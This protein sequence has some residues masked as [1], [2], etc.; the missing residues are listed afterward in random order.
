MKKLNPTLFIILLFCSCEKIFEPGSLELQVSYC[1]N[2]YQG[3]KPDIGAQAHLYKKS[4]T[5][6]V[7]IDSISCIDARVGYLIDNKGKIMDID[8]D[9]E[10]EVGITGILTI[11][12]IK[13]G[14]YLL[15]LASEGRWTFSHKY[16]EINPGETL[17][18]V[19]N[20]GYLHE[21]EDGGEYW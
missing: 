12:N 18:L 19:K 20:F 21:F 17:K 3:Y 15:I 10:G 14:D 6:G 2:A 11:D 4:H 13:P 1:Y 8:D 7:F 16:I 9:Y 5:S